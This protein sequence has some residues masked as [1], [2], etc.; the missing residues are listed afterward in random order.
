MILKFIPS[1]KSLALWLGAFLMSIVAYSQDPQ[2]PELPSEAQKEAPKGILIDKI[3]AKVDNQ[4]LLKSDLEMAYLNYM[5]S[6]QQSFPDTK[7]R[8]L[9]QLI[10]SKLMVAKAEIDSVMVNDLEVENNVDRRM[11]MIVAQS[12]G[13]REKLEAFYGKSLDQIKDELRDQIKEQLVVQKMQK[14]LTDN[15]KVT[16]AEVRKFFNKIPKDSLPYLNKEVEIAQIVK[17]PDVN[18]AQKDIARNKLNEIRS[19]ILNG[20]TTFEEMAQKHSADGSARD[21]GNLGWAGRGMMVPEFEAAALRLRPNEISAPIESQFGFHLIQLI[22]R[23]GNEYNSRHILIIPESSPEDIRQAERYLDSLR[24]RILSDTITFEKAAKEYSDDKMTGPAGGF[25]MDDLG[26][27]RVSVEDLDPV[28]YFTI[29]T[30]KTG[31]ITRPMTF[32]LDDGKEAVR[33]FYY[34]SSIP[35]HQANL[36]DDWT[37]I[38]AA[39]LN[40]KKARVL[41]KWFDKAREDVFISLDSEYDYCGLLD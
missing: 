5:S 40:E 37:K 22:E 34:K 24:S 18:R 16:P 21:G 14:T 6:G 31:T 15:I 32:R 28:V 12:G 39:A 27:T 10:T 8:I 11:Q 33:I 13:S 3:I 23:R 25:F 7:C 38:Q 17:I 26:S 36:K 30:L 41:D 4:I 35:P 2:V 9:A 1:S 19:M 20:Q 29:D